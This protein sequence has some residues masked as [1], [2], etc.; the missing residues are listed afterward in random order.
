MDSLWL[1][2]IV[3]A[4]AQALIESQEALRDGCLGCSQGWN[5]DLQSPL[6]LHEVPIE[7]IHK[8]NRGGYSPCNLTASQ[9]VALLPEGDLVVEGAK[10]WIRDKQP[11]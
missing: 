6:L 8:E 9:R 5:L 4:L 7:I 3:E 2:D 1:G 10:T 11:G